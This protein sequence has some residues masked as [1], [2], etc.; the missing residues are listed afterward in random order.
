MDAA[1][2]HVVLPWESLACFSASARLWETEIFP[3][4]RADYGQEILDGALREGKLLWYGCGKEKAGFC[5]PGDLDLAQAQSAPIAQI[6]PH[7]FDRPRDFWEIKEALS[8]GSRETAEFLW[9]TAW[10]GSL[11]AD[12]W[13]PVRRGFET[14]FIPEEKEMEKDP[15]VPR[16]YPFGSRGRSI[17]R[18]LREKWRDGPPVRGLWYS[19]IPDYSPDPFEEEELKRDRVRLLVKRWGILCRPLLERE[20]SEFSWAALLPAMRRMELAGELSAG[21][22]FSGINSLQFA[23]PYIERDLEAAEALSNV[24]W[25]NAADPASPAGLDAE[26]L[27]PR[28][29]SRSSSNRLCFKGSE[30]IAVSLKSGKEACIFIGPDDPDLPKIAAFFSAPKTRKV[31]PEKKIVIETING[32]SAA[33]SEYAEAFK[34]GGFI[35]DRGK[36][37][38]W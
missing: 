23:P 1:P 34:A 15:G 19:L 26:G 36:F 33:S 11:S 14:G 17:P 7:F 8:A 38:L 10:K 32:K 12:S 30:L 37:F 16:G 35:Q 28:L 25:I 22:F 31:L 21:R 24:Y 27:D 3:A 18:A 29:P 4:R 6:D 20:Q 2:P 5:S 9:N 13:E